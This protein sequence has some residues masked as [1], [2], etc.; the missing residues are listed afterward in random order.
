[1]GCISES[2]MENSL[3]NRRALSV[4]SVIKNLTFLLILNVIYALMQGKSPSHAMYAIKH[5]LPSLS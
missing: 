2:N 5:L 3:S 1:M 4:I